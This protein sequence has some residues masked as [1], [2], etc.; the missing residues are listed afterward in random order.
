MSYYRRK[1]DCQREDMCRPHGRHLWCALLCVFLLCP[2]S[3]A[4]SMAPLPAGSSLRFR[5]ITLG[6]GLA[7]STV[8]AIAQ[9]RQGYMWFG[10]QDG[11]QRYDGYDFLTFHHNPGQPDSLADDSVTALAIGSHDEL[12]IGTEDQGL[13]LREPG[14]DR[15]IHYQHDPNDS[16]SLAS[17]T[18]YALLM[19]THGQLWVGTTDGLDRLDG[20]SGHFHHYRIAKSSKGTN[21][22]F[23]LHEDAHGRI[24]IGAQ[25]GLYYYDQ[26]HDVLKLLQ[27]T[28]G[29]MLHEARKLLAGASVNAFAESDS[30]RLW[31]ATEGGLVVLSQ[32]HK[33]AAV[34]QH[35]NGDA[36]SL[37]SSRVRALF[38]DAAGDIWIG[39]Y[40]G[41]VTRLDRAS[42][43]FFNYEHDATDPQSL[44]GDR[45]LTLFRDQTG[46]IWIGTEAAGISIYNPQTREFGYYR[47]RQG[48]RN[49]LASNLVW[50]MYKDARNY[51]WV[52]T[53]GGL[54]RIDPARVNYK[55]YQ[56]KD[57]PKDDQDD[58]AVYEVYGDRQDRLWVGTDYGLYEYRPGSDTFRHIH[59]VARK[60]DSSGNVVNVIFEDSARR[61]WIGTSRGLV[62]FDGRD[63]VT[64][65]LVHDPKRANS[66][67]DNVVVAICETGD[68]TLWLGTTNGLAKF[69][70]QDDAF[71]VYRKI[72]GD[73]QSL[74][75]NNIQSCVAGADNSLWVGTTSGL[76]LLNTKTG[77]FTRYTTANGL[78]NDTVY[79]SLRDRQ[80]DIWVSTDNGLSRLDPHDGTF[81]NYGVTDGL[82]SAEFNGEAA[83]QATDG[84]LFF[85]GINGFNAFYPERIHRNQHV[86]KVAITAFTH[87]GHTA[88]LLTEHGAVTSIS[89]PYRDN[90]LSFALA[91][92][93]YA[94]PA[95][96]RFMYRMDGF[97]KDWHTLRGQHGFTY[98]NLDP[99]TYLLRVR[100][101]NSDGVWSDKQAILSIE[102]LPPPWRSW[103]A[104]VLYAAL[105]F[106]AI[107]IGLKLFARS[108]KREQA[109]S[110]EHQ[111][112]LWAETLHNLIQS[113]MT[114]RDETA[115]AEQLID[116]LVNFAEFDRALFYMEDN[117]GFRLLAFRGIELVE[118]GRLERWPS[119]YSR[120]ML[121]L[122]QARN[123]LLLPVS[124][125]ATLDGEPEACRQYLA[126]PL[127]SAAG[128]FRLLLAG[129]AQPAVERQTMDIAAAMAKQISVAL[130][131]AQLIHELEN[132]A[133]TDSL[134]RLHNR[135]HFL[136]RAE[137]EFERSRRYQRPLSIFLLD[138]DHFKEINDN[139][140]HETGDQVLRTLSSVCRQNLRQLDVIGRYGGEEFVVF[141][142]ETSIALA[143]EVAERLRA[144]IE[145]ASIET[146]GGE[147]RVT[148]SIGVATAT[149]QTDSIAALINEADRALYEA[150][151]AG[152][153]KVVL[154]RSDLGVDT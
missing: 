63:R 19:D 147:I 29:I 73:A 146:A 125:A 69:N 131:N 31:V 104:Y 105:L 47:H 5:H 150:K 62:E 37:P 143:M 32:Q 84:E 68:G 115:I 118:Q 72:A 137:A 43:H 24:W 89:I 128:G 153:N 39:T 6:D 2:V 77:K 58:A 56:M 139:H 154:S 124:D 101:S 16:S 55:Q 123:P 100:G 96:N 71:T 11:L 93:D 111:K 10:T 34:Y 49:S 3:H 17:D 36:G 114:L 148:I 76:N 26:A 18:V 103:W 74:S 127:S 117:D 126:V 14:S 9:D 38:E 79:A 95:R 61:L 140:G 144:G 141:L 15:F 33:V 136:E 41:G 30:G 121:G 102:I 4:A 87:A 120:V 98:T 92:F 107:V 81:Q 82:Q 1:S 94:A 106:V 97:D 133:T 64:R 129:R 151:R 20:V 40:G 142:P 67:P 70:G 35:K 108:V 90:V 78:L 59:L 42:G 52:G 53:D 8:Q 22:V 45:I 50:S 145:Q 66:L 109:L 27:P 116:V 57:R 122:R 48:D 75:S 12:W 113:V 91:A 80:G 99:G 44:G 86:P 25:H 134:T 149:A 54:T 51:V 60:G 135:R 7:Q 132:L 138:A 83:Y 112:R 23:A 46:L 88:P 28:A 65:R 152:R 110:N 21:T 85:G 130:D 119:E 13:D